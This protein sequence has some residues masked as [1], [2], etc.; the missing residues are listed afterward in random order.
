MLRSLSRK[1][2]KENTQ[3]R[4]EKLCAFASFAPLREKFYWV[5]FSFNITPSSLTSGL[6]YTMLRSLSRKD[7]RKTRKDA[8]KNFAPLPPLRLCVKNSFGSFF[9]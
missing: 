9:F 3:R 1:D 4:K 2:A 7:A 8:N 6:I 5:H